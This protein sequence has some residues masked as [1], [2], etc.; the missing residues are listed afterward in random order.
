[1]DSD[2]NAHV[3]DERVART[4]SAS[5]L[6]YWGPAV[7]VSLAMFIG[8]IDSTLMNVAIP[9]IVTDLDTTVTVVQGAISFYA[10]VMAALILPGGKLSSMYGVRRL[11]TATLLVYGVGTTLAALSWNVVVLYVG[12]SVIEG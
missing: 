3:L 7:A 10:M 12:W 8:V 9:S 1:M 2:A 4:D 11:M 5:G 6:A